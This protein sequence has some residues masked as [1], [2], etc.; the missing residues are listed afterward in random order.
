MILVFKES[1]LSCSICSRASVVVVL[2]A[3]TAGAPALAQAAVAAVPASSQAGI[4]AQPAQQGSRG[5]LVAAAPVAESRSPRSAAREQPSPVTL[6]SI[7]VRAT[8]VDAAVQ[9]QRRLTPGAVSVVSGKTF[10]QRSVSNMADALR[11]VPGVFIQSNTGGDDGVISIR[12]SNLS[13]LSYD[14]SGVALFQDGL[15][16]TTADGANHNRLMDPLAAHAVIVADGPNALTYGASDLGG[17]IN[18]ISRTAR[19]SDPRQLYMLGGEYG[20]FDGRASTGGVSG[21]FDGMLTLADKHFSGYQQ[22]SREQRTSVDGN[23]GWQVSHDLGLRVFATYIDSRQQ[24]AGSLTRAEFNANPRQAD[25]SY[26]LGNHQ[27]N[28]KTGRLAATGTWNI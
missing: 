25:P 23:A 21:D 11:Y 19:N 1:T 26:L 8:A 4:A 15:P 7:D 22:H 10:Q 13:A 5:N 12:G 24:L 20:L 27:L 3:M 17:A 16:V 18:F 9:A 28:V 6:P 2:M 14:K